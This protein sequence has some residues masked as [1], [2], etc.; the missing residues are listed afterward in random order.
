MLIIGENLNSTREK[1][2]KIIENRDEKSVQDLARRQGENGAAILDVTPSTASGNT[3]DNMEWLVRT[4]QEAVNVPLCIDSPNIEE[5]EKGLE[6][7]NWN[8]G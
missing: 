2:K 3:K 6:A 5:I 4:V 1:V 7:Y 8:Y